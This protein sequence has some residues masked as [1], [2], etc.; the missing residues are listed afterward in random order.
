MFSQGRKTFS[1]EVDVWHILKI[2]K[3]AIE[4]INI[5]EQDIISVMEKFVGS[6]MCSTC[7]EIRALLGNKSNIPLIAASVFRK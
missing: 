3:Y 4:L 2:S 6:V 7:L 5:Y 1:Y